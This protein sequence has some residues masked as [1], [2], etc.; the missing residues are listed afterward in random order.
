MFSCYL[1][2]RVV[3]KLKCVTHCSLTRGGLGSV[4]LISSAIF[5][6]VNTGRN[7]LLIFFARSESCLRTKSADHWSL[8]GRIIR[9][10]WLTWISSACS[11]SC[12]S[13]NLVI[14]QLMSLSGYLSLRKISFRLSHSAAK[15][16]DED[17]S[18]CARFNIVVRRDR[19]YLLSTW[20][21]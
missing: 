3:C 4:T 1:S 9:M 20:L 18:L 14:V 11:R 10:G 21:W 7:S 8:K 2:L 13:M 17:E 5:L 16:S 19:L 12:D 6:L 15:R